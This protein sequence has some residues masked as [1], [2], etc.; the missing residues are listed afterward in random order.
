MCRGYNREVGGGGE[1]MMRNFS[2]YVI[3]TTSCDQYAICDMYFNN[4]MKVLEIKLV[5]FYL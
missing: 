2:S 3:T 5:S 1:E 4:I